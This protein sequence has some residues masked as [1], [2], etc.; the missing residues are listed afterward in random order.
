LGEAHEKNLPTEQAAPQAHARVPRA[1]G[2]SERP[3]GSRSTP[4]QGTQ[5]A[6]SLSAK[7]LSPGQPDYPRYTLPRQRRIRHKADFDA[8]H[9]Q[10]QR[11]GNAFFGVSMRV[12]G[13]KGARL[14]LAV[15]IKVAGSG[16]ERNRIRRVIRE[17]FRLNQRDL[18]VVDLV[19]SARNRARGATN[20]DLRSSL[21][22]L[23]ALIRQRQSGCTSP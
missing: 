1:D 20:E 7:P 11:L 16:V 15:S 8:I 5:E 9:A 19:V 4:C 10:G 13:E 23:W 22:E 6:H 12:N 3:S 2:H 18:P 17:S 14:G 21:I